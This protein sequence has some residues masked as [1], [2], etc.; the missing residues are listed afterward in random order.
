MSNCH[1]ADGLEVQAG[2]SGV[3]VEAE[4]AT[5]SFDRREDERKRWA[6]EGPRREVEAT[7]WRGTDDRSER[8]TGETI[9]GNG[10]ASRG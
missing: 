8:D 7:P 3:G 5:S 1:W 4:E 10:V 6:A 9:A 2:G